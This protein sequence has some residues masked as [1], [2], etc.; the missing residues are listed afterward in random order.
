[1][2]RWTPQQVSLMKA[3]GNRQCTDFLQSHG[4]DTATASISEKFDSPAGMLYQQVLLARVEGRPEPT[5]LPRKVD[6]KKPLG[7]LQGFGSGPIAEPPKEN[8]VKKI[9]KVAVPVATA[10]VVVGA[11]FIAPR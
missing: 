6:N 3:G 8:M 11:L 4:I 10:V 1:M 2:D 9:V 5:E 7:K